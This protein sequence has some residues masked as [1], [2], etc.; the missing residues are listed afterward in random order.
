MQVAHVDFFLQRKVEQVIGQDGKHHL[1][2]LE[3]REDFLLFD[4]FDFRQVF[5]SVVIL[6]KGSD[7]NSRNKL[8]FIVDLFDEFFSV[9]SVSVVETLSEVFL[10]FLEWEC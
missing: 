3:E 1:H 4:I 7:L 2:F 9:F 10:N 8:F 6:K 5:D